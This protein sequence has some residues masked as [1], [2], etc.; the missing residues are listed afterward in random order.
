MGRSDRKHRGTRRRI[1]VLKKLAYLTLL[2]GC[3]GGAH[4]NLNSF[5][6]IELDTPSSEVIAKVGQPY[7]IVHK[8]DGSTEYEYI[9][10]IK[11]G[12]RDLEDRRYVITIKDGKVVSKHV[13]YSSPPAYLFDSYEMQTT[14]A[15]HAPPSDE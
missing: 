14:Q 13:K 9:E 15:G 6:D 12:G 3:C 5:N 11:A 7:S 1:T 2:A 4:M 10:R 8:A